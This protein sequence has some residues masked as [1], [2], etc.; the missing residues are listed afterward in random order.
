MRKKSE[1][2]ANVERKKLCYIWDPR[3]PHSTWIGFSGRRWIGE[4]RCRTTS[5][6]TSRPRSCRASRARR[7]LFNRCR[8]FIRRR[9]QSRHRKR[10]TETSKSFSG[11]WVSTGSRILEI[12][13]DKRRRVVCRRISGDDFFCRWV[14]LHQEQI[15]SVPVR[16]Q[17]TI[18]SW[19]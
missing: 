12:N 7:R 1:R 15:A 14:R 17:A 4:L 8:R 9:R 18:R 3:S 16:I 11:T 2:I 5:T 6:K 10:S 13:R 19:Q